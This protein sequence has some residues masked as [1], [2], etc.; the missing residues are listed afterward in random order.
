MVGQRSPGEVLQAGPVAA[1][2]DNG[3]PFVRHLEEQ[4][5]GELFDIVAVVDSVV[6]QR[7]AKAPEFLD[8]VG[9]AAILSFNSRMRSSNCGPNTFRARAQAAPL[10]EDREGIQVLRS[11][12]QVYDEVLADVLEPLF[13]LGRQR[14]VAAKGPAWP[15][16]PVPR[17]SRAVLLPGGMLDHRNDVHQC[18]TVAALMAF[19]SLSSEKLWGAKA[20]ACFNPTRVS[21][22]QFRGCSS[23]IWS[24]SISSLFLRTKNR[25]SLQ[26]VVRLQITQ[27]CSLETVSSTG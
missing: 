5:V 15:G 19:R 8:D 18:L 13:L 25:E 12:R 23:R 10:G 27:S 3:G 24:V 14:P 9:H 17:P 6:A 16:P 2:R 11:D 21:G 26:I 1:R 7:V 4:Q 22:L 20:R